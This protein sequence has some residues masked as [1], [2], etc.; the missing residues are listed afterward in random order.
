MKNLMKSASCG[1]PAKF[2]WKGEVM[3]ENIETVPINPTDKAKEI[4]EN[5]ASKINNIPPEYLEPSGMSRSAQ[6]YLKGEFEEF[7]I[8][9]RI[10]EAKGSVSFKSKNGKDITL[11]Y[12]YKGGY[13]KN[14]RII[15]KVDDD[16]SLKNLSFNALADGTGNNV[17]IVIPNEGEEISFR[18]NGEIV[19]LSTKQQSDLLNK[20]NGYLGEFGVKNE[21]FKAR[22]RKESG[23]ANGAKKVLEADDEEV[24]DKLI[25]GF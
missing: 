15:M 19:D 3:K 11:K 10:D 12:R 2:V 5:L 18:I 6:N 9:D 21:E 14:D 17:T 20:M 1:N 7:S 8:V 4:H 25:E 22:K 16:F 23:K 24:A 13:D